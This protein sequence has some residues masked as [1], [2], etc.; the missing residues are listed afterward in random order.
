MLALH[1]ILAAVAFRSLFRRDAHNLRGPRWIWSVVIPA[2]VSSL[3]P[4]A[5]WVAPIGPVAYFLMARRR[6]E[7]DS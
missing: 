2:S 7:A 6:P 4:D 5:A 1:I 3:R